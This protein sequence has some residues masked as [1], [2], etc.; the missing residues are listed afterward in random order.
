MAGLTLQ[1]AKNLGIVVAIGLIVLMV[2]T[3][4][5]IK[6]VTMKLI[7]MG[8]MGAMAL[9]VWSQRSSLQDCADKVTNRIPA[10]DTRPLTCT[11][12][13]KDVTIP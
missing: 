11:F 6:N 9:L 12:L 2:L 13:G 5:F 4:W 3:A 7:L 10:Q 1:S 8:V